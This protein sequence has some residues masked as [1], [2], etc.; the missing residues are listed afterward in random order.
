MRIN[1]LIRL[2]LVI[3]FPVIAYC[4]DGQQYYFI[5]ATDVSISYLSNLFGTVGDVL[6]GGSSTPLISKIFYYFNQGVYLFT[7]ALLS[8]IILSS[9]IATSNE[10]KFVTEKF[11]SWIL[12]R[13]G[14]AISLLI[15]LSSGYCM[16]QVA[17]MWSVTQGIGLANSM[18]SEAVYNIS[19]A[20][21]FPNTTNATET[22]SA[23]Q[24]PVSNS[25]SDQLTIAIGGTP[26]NYL[27][28][29]AS[30]SSVS[31]LQIFRSAYCA[32]TVYNY[33]KKAAAINGAAAPSSS[34]YGYF[35]DT[36]SHLCFG[37]KTPGVSGAA[38]TFNCQCGEYSFTNPDSAVGISSL[39]TM[40]Q[41]ANL[42]YGYAQTS[43][44]TVN[45]NNPK[46]STNIATNGSSADMDQICQVLGGT[47]TDQSTCIPAVSIWSYAADYMQ[48]ISQYQSTEIDTTQE[49]TTNGCSWVNSSN[50]QGWIMAASY[51]ADLVRVGNSCSAPAQVTPLA[52]FLPKAAN[53]DGS[54]IITSCNTNCHPNPCMTA[55]SGYGTD[56]TTLCSASNL[57]N[58]VQSNWNALYNPN[59]GSTS[60]WGGAGMLQNMY[61]NGGSNSDP[62]G[63]GYLMSVSSSSLYD[64]SS[65]PIT[66]STFDDYYNGMLNSFLL[67]FAINTAYEP[68]SVGYD[69]M[70]GGGQRFIVNGTATLVTYV[71]GEILGIN[72]YSG[73]TPS[74]IFDYTVMD[75]GPPTPNSSCTSCYN[76]GN[77]SYYSSSCY[78][79]GSTSSCINGSGYGLFGQIAKEHN[80]ES[81]VDPLS[82]VASI[83]RNILKYTL[84]YQTNLIENIFVGLQNLTTDIIAAF[85]AAVT[86]LAIIGFFGP[87]GGSAILPMTAGF[88][89]L[90]EVVFKAHMILLFS[91]MPL[92][93]ALTIMFF[94]IGLM[95]GVYLPYLPFLL[96]TAGV[97]SWFISVVEA[98]IAA[99]LVAMGVTHP[100]GHELMGR[101][102]QALILLLGVFIRPSTMI[103]GFIAAISLSYASMYMLNL[104]FAY[105][106]TEGLSAALSANSG[107]GTAIL[108]GLL[109]VIIYAYSCYAILSQTYSLI[110]QV[111]DKVMRWIG[112]PRDTTGRDAMA[113]AGGVKSGTMDSGGSLAKDGVKGSM[114][115][116]KK[117]APSLDALGQL[118]FQQ[119]E[120]E[121]AVSEDSIASED[122]EAAG[123]NGGDS[124]GSTIDG[125][126]SLVIKTATS[127]GGTKG[128]DSKSVSGVNTASGADGKDNLVIKTAGAGT[129]ASTSSTEAKVT[130]LSLITSS[131]TKVAASVGSYISNTSTA[132]AVSNVASVA[133][134]A[135]TNA[136]TNVST[137]G[138]KLIAAAGFGSTKS[139]STDNVSTKGDK[140]MAGV[141]SQ[142]LGADNKATQQTNAPDNKSMLSQ[143]KTTLS[144]VASASSSMAKSAVAGVSYV[145]S[146][147]KDLGTSV[148]SGTVTVA[149]QVSDATGLTKAA[150]V[151]A[152]VLTK[153]ASASIS[154]ASG[155]KDL[156]T[157]AASAT[158]TAAKQ[159]SDATG[160]TKA[161]TV[162]ASVLTK[163]A[164]ASISVAKSTVAGVSSV[165]SGTVNAAKVVAEKSG[166]NFLVKKTK[167][168]GSYV[169]K[170]Y[171]KTA[172]NYIP[173]VAEAKDA[174]KPLID[175]IDQQIAKNNEE[176]TEGRTKP[177]TPTTETNKAPGVDQTDNPYD[178]E[179]KDKKGSDGGG[180]S[181]DR[182][183]DDTD[184]GSDTKSR[185]DKTG[186]TDNLDAE[187]AAGK[188]AENEAA[189]KAGS[190][191]DDPKKDTDKK[192]T[193][194]K[195]D[196]E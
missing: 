111:P 162:S 97:I 151:S 109:Y 144:K 140:P 167:D 48:F 191:K 137:A 86:P 124:G 69:L 121:A 54:N 38:D 55:A 180:S 149:K 39:N 112:M 6:V 68:D 11:N 92:A 57:D 82:S 87:F 102:E 81:Y 185:K 65:D 23:S 166:L 139:S 64:N 152:S 177:V 30:G 106:F 187:I 15:P 8:Y 93:V 169:A 12:I 20:G 61:A 53:A 35:I 1:S 24:A 116:A 79:S 159:V 42:I 49:T 74:E 141:I 117:G 125:K 85:I 34:N 114:A 36:N 89:A 107:Y 126:D 98:M 45:N 157:S 58:T 158:V 29:V 25:P 193:G 172:E 63:I 136:I 75:A 108:G 50:Q 5:S 127:D 130:P 71:I 189:K 32:Y 170:T 51:Y 3:L 184:T 73:Q 88:M 138:S 2:V 190:K 135:G 16:M 181:D 40:Y 192:Q 19:S 41:M 60:S 134:T 101:S 31:F 72:I 14:L 153:V 160:L 46:A 175:K 103:I 120:I 145:A 78:V 4:S 133:K 26:S 105:V 154:V 44:N 17:V 131:V 59:V 115:Q 173:G 66:S 77:A 90:V 143:A 164:S 113:L 179:V 168:G 33:D 178:K 132:K 142:G 196:N 76:S 43:Y 56:T 182:T 67:N 161:A 9:V 155:A 119:N 150:T 96:F 174:A 176:F 100:K 146:G 27:P 84:G 194:K 13:S 183:T 83:G 21:G 186:N 171:E 195:D 147:A 52:D 28:T 18:W 148:A 165:A 10:G 22:S 95:L 110:F 163:V 122:I 99:P 118:S 7:A 188:A 80:A 94:T 156:G 62:L 70:T 104:T 129:E 91:Y 37:S 123:D 128:T 47:N